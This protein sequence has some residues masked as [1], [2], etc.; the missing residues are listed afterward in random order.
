MSVTNIVGSGVSPKTLERIAGQA[1]AIVMALGALDTAKS[2]ARMKEPD[3]QETIEKLRHAA[4]VLN[5][6]VIQGEAA[7]GAHP[8][9][10]CEACGVEFVPRRKD[11][12][13]HSDACRQRAY[14]ERKEQS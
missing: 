5:D 13:F 3:R 4:R 9:V 6:Q 1:S 12:R 10:V 8:T 14:R 2:W 11:A 7:A